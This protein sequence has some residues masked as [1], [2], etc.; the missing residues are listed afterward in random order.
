LAETFV[1][2]PLPAIVVSDRD[3]D[4]LISIASAALSRMPET[5]ESLLTEL[6]RARIVCADALPDGTVRLGST[7]TFCVDGGPSRRLT[8]VLPVDAD[9]I[10]GKISIL[11]PVGVALLGLSKGQTITL[12]VANQLRRL[13]VQAVE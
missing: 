12:Q 8:L 10:D 2:Q 4:Q 3:Y 11:T 1:P 13:V 6:G 5:A 9:I 7:V